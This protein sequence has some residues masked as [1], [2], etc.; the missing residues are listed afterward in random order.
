[1]NELEKKSVSNCRISRFYAKN[2]LE[3]ELLVEPGKS[4]SN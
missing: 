3:T 2:Y 4:V 1:M